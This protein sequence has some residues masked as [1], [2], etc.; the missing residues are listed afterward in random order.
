[1]ARRGEGVPA[2]QD[3][4]PA[5]RLK[6]TIKRRT[7]IAVRK[8][9]GSARRNSRARAGEGG[10]SATRT[11]ATARRVASIR[12]IECGG[13][14]IDLRRTLR[15]HTTDDRI[16]HARHYVVVSLHEKRLPSWSASSW[17]KKLD[18][19]R[20]EK[21]HRATR[22]LPGDAT[23]S[24]FAPSDLDLALRGVV[25]GVFATDDRGV[26]VALLPPTLIAAPPETR[27]LSGRADP[28]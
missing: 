26:V 13:A 1:V 7:N 19:P 16:N 8:G 3:L 22:L 14:I 9:D 15:M 20:K 24:G 25:S 12:S 10:V 11:Y 18:A 23:A 2:V 4:H 17:K 21:G 27:A 28:G 6:T 5:R